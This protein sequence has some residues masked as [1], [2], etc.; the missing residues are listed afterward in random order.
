[1][2]EPVQSPPNAT[3]RAMPRVVTIRYDKATRQLDIHT[4]GL[5]ERKLS[6]RTVVST[7]E[8]ASA[9]AKDVR[10]AAKRCKGLIVCSDARGLRILN[11]PFCTLPLY[12]T[13][14]AEHF[15]ASSDP[16]V[17]IDYPNHP[18]DA[19]GVWETL[20]LNSP[21]WNRTPY[22]DVKFLPAACELNICEEAKLQRYWNFEF[23]P[24]ISEFNPKAFFGNFDDL[25]SQKF[26]EIQADS[27][28]MGLSGGNDSRLAAHFLAKNKHR[29][30]EIELVTYAAHPNSNEFHYASEVASALNLPAPR[31]HLLT[32][33]HYQDALGYLPQWSAGQI[34]NQHGHLS[35][36]LQ[37]EAGSVGRK[38]HLSNYYTDAVFGWDCGQP[39]PMDNIQRAVVYQTIQNASHISESVRAEMLADCQLALSPA[40]YA[41]GYLSS[42]E[43]YKYI[44]ERHPRFHMSLAYVQSQFMPTLLPFADI[45]VLEMAMQAPLKLRERKRILDELLAFLNPAL[46]Q[47]GS[48][49]SHE[50]FHGEKSR[51]INGTLA[52]RLEFLK[53]RLLNMST[54]ILAKLTD[55]K[56]RFGNPYQ[57]EDQISVYR[58][59][60]SHMTSAVLANEVLREGLGTKALEQMFK[61]DFVLRNLAERLH[62]ISF[63]HLSVVKH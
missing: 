52:E 49:G 21:L 26:S 14:T 51:L 2:F 37:Q 15:T 43:E 47:I 28:Y 23:E 34:N 27:L 6:G 9:D 56:I 58:K 17:L 41:E 11:D 4:H 33:S 32:D 60:F 25:L 39:Q 7:R 45:D 62:L 35:S 54:Q 20:L 5:Y 22:Q 46:K 61:D 38:V 29:F 53:F 24:A 55:G 44:A 30:S 36:F 48:S 59:T 1:M 31:L 57:T 40:A 10:E 8:A 3:K 13:D 42:Y 16:Q 12:Y 18:F 19:V 50:Y 63:H